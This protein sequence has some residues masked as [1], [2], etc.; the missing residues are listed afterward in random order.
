MSVKNRNSDTLAC[1]NRLCSRYDHTV[2]DLAPQS[3][4]FFFALFFLTTDV[5][6]DVVFHF[7]PVFEGL[8][9]S[10]DCLI[11]SSNYF[12]WFK[13]FPC[14]KYR[15]ITLDRAVW[16]NS[17]ESSGCSQTFLL[18]FDNIKMFRVDF[19]HY[20]RNIRC[21]AMCT[22]VGNNRCLCFCVFFF[23]CF[24]LVFGHIYRRKYKINSCSN[25]FYF[26]YIHNNDLFNCFRHGSVHFPSATYCFFI[27]LA[28][29]SCTCSK[30]NHFKPWMVLK[31]RNKSLSN[32]SCSTQNTDSQFFTHNNNLLTF[33]FLNVSLYC[34]HLSSLYIL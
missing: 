30:C 21:P 34:T 33:Y 24:D 32:H 6:D 1:D 22:V 5:W 7:R 14:C 9:S 19:R 2:F 26:V 20:H 28:C 4:R 8:T 17:D 15:C 12:I 13:F 23:D 3:Q 18:I 11:C 10:G 29:A 27:G 25:L 31:K 16:L